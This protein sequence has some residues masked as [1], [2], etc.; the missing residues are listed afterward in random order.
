M[1]PEGIIRCGMLGCIRYQASENCA[2]MKMVIIIFTKVL[3][4]LETVASGCLSM[5]YK[6]RKS[7]ILI[8]C[9]LVLSPKSTLSSLELYLD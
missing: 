6:K 4:L 7:L 2:A 1:L 9:N 8:S 3:L 5:K